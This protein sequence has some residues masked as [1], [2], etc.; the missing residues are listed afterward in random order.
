MRRSTGAN[1][2]QGFV[3][4]KR[5]HAIIGKPKQDTW[6]AWRG[7]RGAHRDGHVCVA[8]VEKVTVTV[9]VTVVQR[10]RGFRRE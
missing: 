10:S 9:T 6:R 1:V 7:S 2:I 3:G 4:I 5:V 8:R